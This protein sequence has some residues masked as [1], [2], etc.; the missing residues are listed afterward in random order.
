M[1]WRLKLARKTSIR[2]RNRTSE[3]SEKTKK[4]P[5]K[6][7]VAEDNKTVANGSSPTDEVRSENGDDRQDQAKPPKRDN[8]AR[9]EV[10]ERATRGLIRMEGR[11]RRRTILKRF[12]Q[13]VIIGLA[14]FGAVHYGAEY[15]PVEQA[16]RYWQELKAKLPF[17]S[18]EPEQS[19]SLPTNGETVVAE[20]SAT[21]PGIEPALLLVRS[22]S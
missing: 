22:P 2:S 18:E 1:R 12:V 10:V 6:K 14:V 9:D 13:L 17:I 5:D 3:D 21:C 19:S 4:T 20:R 16:Q 11:R 15:L 7:T 8:G